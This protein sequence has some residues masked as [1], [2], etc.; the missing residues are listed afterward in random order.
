MK[1]TSGDS[2]IINIPESRNKTVLKEKRHLL[3]ATAAALG[4]A[5]T[6]GSSEQ[7]LLFFT[8]FFVVAMG[9]VGAYLVLSLPFSIVKIVLHHAVPPRVL[10]LIFDTLALTLNTSCA[11]TIVYLACNGNSDANWLAICQQFGDF[12]QQ[13]SGAVVSAFVTVVILILLSAS[14]LRKV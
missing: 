8:Q 11:A 4:V 1:S 5:I 10:L 7:T 6:M 13:S 3:G 12:C 9:I 14:A 2:T